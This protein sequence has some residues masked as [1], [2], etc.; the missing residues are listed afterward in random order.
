MQ[1]K[2]KSRLVDVLVILVCLAGSAV[3]VWQFWKELNR[4]LVKLNEE[5][6]ATITFKYNTAQRKFSDNLVWD[7]LRQNS[8]VYN[9]DTI[10][11]AD[12]SEATIYF[13]DGNIMDLSEN[14]MAR[15]SLNSGGGAAI[16]F[17]G[18]QISVQT[19]SDNGLTITSGTSVVDVVKGASLTASSVASSSEGAASGSASQE[20]EDVF[21]VQV[22][23]GSVA[24]SSGGQDKVALEAGDAADMKGDGKVL[25]KVL[26]VRSPDPDTKYL[27][28]DGEQ[29]V[30]PFAWSADGK[31]VRLEL[32]DT[33]TFATIRESYEF[34]EETSTSMP[35]PAGTHYWRMVCGNEKLSGKVTIYNTK[36]PASVAPAQDYT[37]RFRTVKPAIRFIWSESERSTTYAF[38]V[39]NNPQMNNPVISQRI[40]QTSSIVT[41]LDVGTW[42]WRVTPYYTIN[43]IGFSHPSEVYSFSIEK[44]GALEPPELLV[45]KTGAIVSTKVPGSE[46]TLPQNIL[47]SWKDNPEASSYKITITPDS[48]AYGSAVTQTVN[49]NYFSLDT[50]AHKVGNGSWK[51]SVEMTDVEG[52]SVQ[53]EKNPFMA[54]DSEISQKPLFPNEGYIL[55]VGRVFDTNFA[56]KSNLGAEMEVQFAKDS[57]FRNLETSIVTKNTSTSGLNL[58]AGDYYWRIVTT[59]D[60]GIFTSDP[61]HFVVEPTLPAP[62]C[63]TPGNDTRVVVSDNKT[64]ALSWKPV[65]TADYYQLRV[66]PSDDMNE[67]IYEDTFIENDGSSVYTKYV[68]F[69]GLPERSYIWTVQAFREET[70]GRSRASSL[71]GKYSFYLRIL[72]PITLSDPTDKMVFEG[73][74]V[75]MN[76]PEMGWN[77][78]DELNESEL[79]IYKGSVA[80]EN[81][82]ASLEDPERK[83]T[84][85]RLYEGTYF[86]TVRGITFDDLDASS[87]QIRNFTVKKIPPMD[88]PEKV[89]P[90]TSDVFS[91]DYFDRTLD[92]TFSWKPVLYATKYVVT[93]SDSDGNVLKTAEVASPDTSCS[94]NF[95]DIVH[96]GIFNWTV[97]ART[98]FDDGVVRYGNTEKSSFR[99]YLP[100]MDAPVKNAVGKENVLDE[101]IYFRDK[102]IRFSWKTVQ[103]ADEYVFTLKN[104]HG[105]VI[106]KEFMRSR[107]A[108]AAARNAVPDTF[109]VYKDVTS[110]K[111]GTYQWSVE[112]RNYIN[113]KMMQPGKSEDTT[114]E[115]KVNNMPAPEKVYPVGG[116]LV[117]NELFAADKG[118]RFTWKPVEFAGDY[119]F[120]LYDYNDNLMVQKVVKGTEYTYND[121]DSFE[122]NKYSWTVE[123]R[124][125]LGDTLLQ[126][127]DVRKSQFEIYLPLLKTPEKVTPQ[128]NYALGAEFFLMSKK[129]DFKW[130]PVQYADEYIFTVTDPD[131]E[132]VEQFDISDV[133]SS[134]SLAYQIPSEKL[135][136][137]GDY[138]WTVE[139]LSHFHGRL[140]QHGE[141]DESTFS[142][143][144][145]NLDAP[146]P[147]A[148]SS[149]TVLTASF[150]KKDEPLTFSWRTVPLADEYIFKIY[151]PSGEVVAEQAMT[152]TSFVADPSILIAA[153]EYTW[154]VEALSHYKG[155]L[156]Q[157]GNT[158]D[159]HFTVSLPDLDAPKAL[160]PSAG[161]V[162]NT[163][164]FKT[165]KPMEFRWTSIS[166]ADDY[167]FTIYN[168]DVVAI[169]EQALLDT[170]ITIDTYT[171]VKSG[172]YT[173]TVEARTR[174]KDLVLQH[175]I[176]TKTD[177]TT[178]IPPLDTPALFVP[179]ENVEYNSDY[180]KSTNKQTFRWNDVP[181]ADEYQFT[182]QKA[183]G[184]IV[185]ETSVPAATREVSLDT[186]IF[187]YEGDYIWT[188][189]A[190]T[191]FRDKLLQTSAKAERAFAVVMPPLDAPADRL[192]A[193]GTKFGVELFKRD[194]AIN[195]SWKPVAGADR[196]VVRVRDAEGTVVSENA[197]QADGAGNS[198]L[199]R[200][201]APASA[202]AVEGDYTWTI[203]AQ[204][205]YKNRVL[206]T[207]GEAENAF[208]VALPA[209]SAPAIVSGSPLVV[210]ASYIDSSNFVTLKWS[211]V[212][213]ADEYKVVVYD[214]DE[215]V[216]DELTVP[217]SRNAL[218]PYADLP[219][220][221]YA[222]EGSFKWTVTANINYL[223]KLFLSSNTAEGEVQVVFPEMTQPEVVSPKVEEVLGT[224]Y[225]RAN[226]E[227][228]FE[229]QKIDWASDY[230]FCFYDENGN[231]LMEKISYNPGTEYNDLSSLKPG[232]YKW[233]VQA[234]YKKNGVVLVTGEIQESEFNIELPTLK[235]PTVD[236]T[237]SLYG[238]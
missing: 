226:R 157:H 33:K 92:V 27:S 64:I 131:G 76:P 116:E 147:V 32:S 68:S 227:I 6:I 69:A 56:W 232:K 201:K 140:L 223:G 2:T 207:S 184:T 189:E 224:A 186:E 127:G 165:D 137:R 112:A 152:G 217:S 178:N 88:A 81:I 93:V 35:L 141:K 193:E 237:G 121:L 87:R 62:E 28:F 164:F 103:Y 9:G 181:L 63:V 73:L 96:D 80:E 48:P 94:V 182:L 129:L 134:T 162:L 215:S 85:P 166:N 133:K 213:F 221:D 153:G 159:N 158:D 115:I 59:T 219:I 108:V 142:V 204:I 209:P 110:L 222:K 145:P 174:Y 136:K 117:G 23:S 120:S 70:D 202:V 45:P 46:G 113:G 139:A 163:E 67:P 155:E 42:Y 5:P 198:G 36:A 58:D 183:D 82:V 216:K 234:F 4:T 200:Y 55:S 170:S 148:P 77:S 54:M 135:L 180:F 179:A 31:D 74:D 208:T 106:A 65:E 86:W 89:S 229:W 228:K 205:I 132:V 24:L 161:T 168:Q 124:S 185:N 194:D 114:F 212:E 125:Y 203:E 122:K 41:T 119:V 235:T 150:F 118:M 97:E 105:T 238:N 43:N 172:E 50:A 84:M 66:Y 154:T 171:V 138:K 7:R 176:I 107:N 52:N 233:T 34:S 26:S 57:S 192:P 53:S 3:S 191:Y 83:T 13:S 71:T 38:E 21:R 175:G 177:L 144:I 100:E 1:K 29:I 10:R 195:F 98:I 187:S 91:T 17:S 102:S 151:N 30:V 78:I 210:D 99:V 104:V 218:S 143:I 101:N 44:S 11:T 72:K 130:K 22:Q 95:G 196:Y 231:L 167:L 146:V 51:W 47:F 123:A 149:S 111:P 14:T 25:R 214:Q 190:R 15:V 79:L 188:V 126:N 40:Q 197:V 173:W 75:V 18:G 199:M 109:Y 49:T 90:K 156:F 206:R 230:R 39:A 128:E 220:M 236:N 211:P 12:F 37:A 19:S 160:T 16:D 8:P 20:A 60:A 225:F 61:V 169:E